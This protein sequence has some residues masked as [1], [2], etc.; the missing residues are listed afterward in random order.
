MVAHG[1]NFDVQQADLIAGKRNGN[2]HRPEHG[3]FLNHVRDHYRGR[4]AFNAQAAEDSQILRTVHAS[5]ATRYIKYARGN[6]ARSQVVFILAGCR[7]EHIGRL[8]SR[9]FLN[10]SRAAITTDNQARTIDGFRQATRLGIA[11]FNQGNLVVFAQKG[12]CKICAELA[13]A[14]DND[15]HRNPPNPVRTLR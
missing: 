10:G 9:I 5:N 1:R 14:N 3:L 6:F 2:A 7:H 11:F 4:N 8:H 12:T 15:V 13:A